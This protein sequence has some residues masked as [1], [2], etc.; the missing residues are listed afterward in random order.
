MNDRYA[1]L[2]EALSMKA[3]LTLCDIKSVIHPFPW[4]L[5]LQTIVNI[6]KPH[7]DYCLYKCYNVVTLQVPKKSLSALICSNIENTA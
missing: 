4:T 1:P 3:L 2:H 7:S 6:S 5:L